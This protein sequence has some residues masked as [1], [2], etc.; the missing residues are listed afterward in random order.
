MLNHTLI[1]M[2]WEFYEQGVPKIKISQD[3]GKNRETIIL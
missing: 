2:A 1:I 3:L